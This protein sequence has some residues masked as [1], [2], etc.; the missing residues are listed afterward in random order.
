MG[1]AL[2]QVRRS[3]HS[4]SASQGLILVLGTQD[5]H[6]QKVVVHKRIV[7]VQPLWDQWHCKFFTMIR[8]TLYAQHLVLR[9]A[10]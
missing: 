1:C 4:P 9:L 8:C 10:Q 6:T 5:T 3:V 2:G 7:F